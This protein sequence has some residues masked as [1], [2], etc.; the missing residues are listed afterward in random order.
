MGQACNPPD[1][2]LSQAPPPTPQEDQEKLFRDVDPCVVI[3]CYAHSE[4]LF[5]HR[6]GF[7]GVSDLV[8]H[9]VKFDNEYE[10]DS[11]HFTRCYLTYAVGHEYHD[12]KAG[13]SPHSE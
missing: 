10:E 12:Q 2:S 13:L 1:E 9:V 8:D 5:L 11:G 6:D 7:P 4:S 3:C